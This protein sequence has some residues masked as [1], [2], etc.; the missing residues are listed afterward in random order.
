MDHSSAFFICDAKL[1]IVGMASSAFG[2]SELEYLSDC[3]V[4]YC[5]FTV[6]MK[7]HRSPATTLLLLSVAKLSLARSSIPHTALTMGACHV[8][9]L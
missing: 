1:H 2:T 3:V 9:L 4:W 6:M 5:N 7:R 8:D